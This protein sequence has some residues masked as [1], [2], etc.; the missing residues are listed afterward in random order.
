MIGNDEF[1]LK[2]QIP[3]GNHK[4]PA[5][6]TQGYFSGLKGVLGD[7][8]V[9]YRR[10]KQTG[11]RSEDAPDT[12]SFFLKH[13]IRLPAGMQGTP[14][15]ADAAALYLSIPCSNPYDIGWFDAFYAGEM[16]DLAAL[17]DENELDLLKAH[18]PLLCVGAV[19]FFFGILMFII[20]GLRFKER[21]YPFLS[22]GFFSFTAGILYLNLVPVY[23]AL[24]LSPWLWVTVEEGLT[25][26]LPVGIISFVAMIFS[27]SLTPL[28]R[29]LWKLQ[30]VLTIGVVIWFL[31]SIVPS[32]V[33]TL[34]Y[35]MALLCI[36]A[37]LVAIC[38]STAKKKSMSVALKVALG[39][40]LIF[41]LTAAL[42]VLYLLGVVPFGGYYYGFGT[43][44]LIL[45]FGYVLFDHYRTSMLN[46][47]DYAL[48]LETNNQRILK[49]EQAT[50]LARFEALKSQINPHFLFN[51]LG[52]LMALI[53]ED[54]AMAVDFVQELSR[55]Y[56]YLLVIRD[57]RLVELS[58]ELAFIESYA[59]LVSKRYES[60]VSI[61]IDIG[62]KYLDRRLPPLSLQLLLENALKHNVI[63]ARRPLTVEI[64][65]ENDSR[66]VVRNNL[67]VKNVLETSNKIG[68][69]NLRNQ[70]HFFTQEK[71]M[72]TSDDSYFTAK[73]PL[74]PPAQELENNMEQATT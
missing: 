70:Y 12:R 23:A 43:V 61:R 47:R 32:Y 4:H 14:S 3:T 17:A 42:D 60:S 62:R 71:V 30:L 5:V 31:V 59:Y 21:D 48:K 34:G 56:R 46:A 37:I 16:D 13:L 73:I 58:R 69:E 7:G 2:I 15:N 35:V 27:S 28:L 18:L 52:A 36:A 9:I 45:S 51:T 40:F 33:I 22:L 44:I 25:F 67:Q 41:L 64:Y 11:D 57:K 55:V 65:V 24:D 10:G 66:I 6:Y 53:E 54:R 38:E 49:L 50:L 68:L 39:G 20:F 29:G 72:V 1:W 74:L 19:L 63:S 8:R 26:L